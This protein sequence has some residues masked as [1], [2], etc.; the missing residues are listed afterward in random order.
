MKST[1][2]TV[3]KLKDHFLSLLLAGK[4]MTAEDF[5]IYYKDKSALSEYRTILENLNVFQ[6]IEGHHRVINAVPQK[7]KN[8]VDN[9][10]EIVE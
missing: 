8:M 7:T 2:S 10:I 5:A 3:S 6:K 9:V 4:E 1:D